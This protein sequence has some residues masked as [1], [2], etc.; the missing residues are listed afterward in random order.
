MWSLTWRSRLPCSPARR[1][2]LLRF[3]GDAAYVLVSAS[4][5]PDPTD[6]C[7]GS[8][9]RGNPLCSGAG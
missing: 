9:V 2:R 5:A 7:S 3:H 6:P 8:H 1:G 4:R